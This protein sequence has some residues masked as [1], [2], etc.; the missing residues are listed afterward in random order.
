MSEVRARVK[1][2]FEFAS[3]NQLI[4]HLDSF[5]WDFTPG[6]VQLTDSDVSISARQTGSGNHEG[7]AAVLLHLDRP[8]SAVHADLQRLRLHPEKLVLIRT[9]RTAKLP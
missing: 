8:W 3:K 9:A 5:D 7:H 6:D 1:A 2:V 4:V